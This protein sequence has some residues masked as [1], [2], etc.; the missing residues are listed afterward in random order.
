MFAI[1]GFGAGRPPDWSIPSATAVAPPPP[2]C[3]SIS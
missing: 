2:I 3:A 1:C